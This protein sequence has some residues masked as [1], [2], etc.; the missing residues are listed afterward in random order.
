M[1]TRSTRVALIAAVLAIVLGVALT[2]SST[3]RTRRPVSQYPQRLVILGFDGMDPTLTSAW[4]RQG[5][6]PNMKR[7]AEQG[8]MY[9]LGTTHSAESPTAWA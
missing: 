7:L 5:K 3:W 9:P 1:P 6:L 4:M 8:G 2:R